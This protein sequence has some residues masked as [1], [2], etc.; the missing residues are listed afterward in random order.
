M[1]DVVNRGELRERLRDDPELCSALRERRIG[2]RDRTSGPD[3]VACG[4]STSSVRRSL[5]GRFRENHRLSQKG[6]GHAIPNRRLVSDLRVNGKLVIADLTARPLP[7]ALAGGIELL[8]LNDDELV[9]ANRLRSSGAHYVLVSR[10]SAPA[11]LAD[12]DAEPRRVDL[13]DPVFEPRD[14]RGTGDSMFAATGVGFARGIGM[15]DAFR[16]GA[17]AGALNATPART[18]HRDPRRLNG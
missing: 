11:I 3:A 5:T 2:P 4:I 6:Q 8:R 7:A 1:L 14:R 9:A 10:G 18:R 15:V 13:V 17:A 16:L 12:G